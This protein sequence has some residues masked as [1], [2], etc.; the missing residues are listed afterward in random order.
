MAFTT[1]INKSKALEFEML[2][3]PELTAHHDSHKTKWREYELP[4][5]P[6]LGEHPGDN[7]VKTRGEAFDASVIVGPPYFEAYNCT[8]CKRGRELPQPGADAHRFLCYCKLDMCWHKG[9]R[10]DDIG[11][12]N[13]DRGQIAQEKLYE[14]SK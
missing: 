8:T 1:K 7:W 13:W 4:A 11:C 9:P 3:I 2:P 6:T 10:R 5:R 12:I 14:E